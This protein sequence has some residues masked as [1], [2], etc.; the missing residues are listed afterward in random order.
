M[1]QNKTLLELTCEFNTFAIY[2]INIQKIN[3]PSVDLN[4]V[5]QMDLIDIHRVFHPTVAEYTFLYKHTKHILQSR[6]K[7]SKTVSL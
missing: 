6:K 7:R 3:F 4:N 5:D 2:K 1:K